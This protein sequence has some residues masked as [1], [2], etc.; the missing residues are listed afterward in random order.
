M[1]NKN[2]FAVQTQ[3]QEQPCVLV[4]GYVPQPMADQLSLYALWEG[5]TRSGIISNYLSTLPS[6]PKD[7]MVSVLAQRASQEW[8]RRKPSNK[9]TFTEF[10]QEARQS[11]KRR[12]ISM[13]DVEEIISRIGQW[14]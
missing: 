11:L 10:L 1:N 13:E 3:H 4:G 2:P 6:P 14:A 5:T 7:Q 9:Q 12:K 8:N